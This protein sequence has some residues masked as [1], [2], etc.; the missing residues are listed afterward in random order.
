MKSDAEIE[1]M[2]D[3]MPEFNPEEEADRDAARNFMDLFDAA[4]PA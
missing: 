2:E 4:G 1:R 3:V